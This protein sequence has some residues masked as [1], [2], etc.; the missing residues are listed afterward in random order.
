MPETAARGFE[1]HAVLQGSRLRLSAQSTS[2]TVS[3]SLHSTLRRR[4]EEPKAVRAELRTA[5]NAGEKAECSGEQCRPAIA[6]RRAE[7]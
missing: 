7:Q 6:G 4:E 1:A 5:S 3:K 2:T